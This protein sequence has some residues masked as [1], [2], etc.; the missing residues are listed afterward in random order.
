[1]IMRIIIIT[2]LSFL[3]VLIYNHADAIPDDCVMCHTMYSNE[4][5]TAAVT[6]N[7]PCWG[8]HATG[9][10]NNI[11]PFT[12]APQIDHMNA[13]DLAGGNFAYIT[14][15][16]A[17]WTGDTKTRGHNVVNTMVTDDNFRAGTYPPGDEFSQ[18]GEGFNNTTFTCAGKYGCH[19]DR[20]II[21]EFKAVRGA[22][23]DG[24]TVLKFGSINE[25]VQGATV[26]TSYRFLYGVKGGED[27][28]WQATASTFDHNEYKGVTTGTESSK[29]YPGGNTISGLCAEC[30]GNFHG[31]T[32]TGGSSPWRRHPTDLSLPGEGT[33]YTAYTTYNVEVPVARTSIPN[34][35]RTQ[36][37]PSETSDDIVMCLSCHRA[38]AS[39][40]Q[41][42]LRWKYED[43]KVGATGST[44]NSGCFVCHSTKDG[45]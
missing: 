38:H 20:N 21:D 30:H 40:Y 6:G 36:V 17:G 11:D 37:T 23:H 39:P 7:S 41:D 9:T 42:I 5:G 24:G 27:P 19:G 13:T 15:N 35:P 31:S 29:T 1:M 28:D 26:G 10:S 2:L 12:Q 3:S 32:D 45:A 14:G 33:E 22:H 4:N 16:K 44:A 18:S 43:M 34:S 25:S 8:C